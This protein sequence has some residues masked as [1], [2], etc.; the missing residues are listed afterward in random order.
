VYSGAG[1]SFTAFATAAPSA[2]V[3][4]GG[5]PMISTT[6]S[7]FLGAVPGTG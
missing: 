7:Y 3:S 5:I 6:F 1:F 4:S 2:P